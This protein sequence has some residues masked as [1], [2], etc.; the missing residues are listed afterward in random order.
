MEGLPTRC[1]GAGVGTTSGGWTMSKRTASERLSL[2]ARAERWSAAHWKTAV[3]GWLGL[4]VLLMGIGSAAGI[5]TLADSQTGSGETARP[6]QLL[7]DAN[8]KTPAGEQVLVHRRTLEAEDSAFL[9][10]VNDVIH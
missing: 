2:A 1:H 5:R 9:A 8:F 6:Q 4:A 3:F 10:A 7:E